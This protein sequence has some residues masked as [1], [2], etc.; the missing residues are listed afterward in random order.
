MFIVL[1][2]IIIIIVSVFVVVVLMS[3]WRT[4][5]AGESSVVE[6]DLRQSSTTEVS[7]HDSTVDGLQSIAAPRV[8]LY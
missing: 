8:A 6:A 4:V 3:G 5:D 2:I 1:C 7:A